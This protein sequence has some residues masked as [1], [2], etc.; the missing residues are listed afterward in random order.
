MKQQNKLWLLVI[1]LLGLAAC[2]PD[3][4]GSESVPAETEEP[5]ATEAPTETAVPDDEAEMAV[6]E[7]PADPAA[8]SLWDTEWTLVGFGPNAE[9]LPAMFAGNLFLKIADGAVKGNSGCNTFSGDLTLTATG[10]SIGTLWSTVMACLDEGRMDFEHA[11]FRALGDVTTWTLSDDTLTLLSGDIRL[12]YEPRL[13]EPDANLEETDWVFNG[14]GSGTGDA[15]AVTSPVNGTTAT[16][17]LAGGEVSGSTG[18]NLFSGSYTLEGQS[19]AFGKLLHTMKACEEAVAG[20]EAII[21][22]G[23]QKVESWEIDGNQLR[24]HYPDGF[25]MY[26]VATE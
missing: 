17:R 21:L 5:S 26:V 8:D 16:L 19:L 24:L 20:Q 6:T 15:A 11:Y 4:S 23:L 18:C 22:T 13:P 12:V 25:L 2:S 1:L 14:S 3:S 9:P 7:E 10:F